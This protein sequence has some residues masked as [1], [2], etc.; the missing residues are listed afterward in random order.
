[1]SWTEGLRRE[2]NRFREQ[3]I[4]GIGHRRDKSPEQ[5]TAEGRTPAEH[6]AALA[7]DRQAEERHERDAPN[8]A[9]CAQCLYEMGAISTMK[10]IRLAEGRELN[11]FSCANCGRHTMV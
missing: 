2:A 9:Y 5:L 11:S 6:D 3:L 1:M 8:A 10:G 4:Q 7:E